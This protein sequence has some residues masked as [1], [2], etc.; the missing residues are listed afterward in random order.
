MSFTRDDPSL[1]RPVG[2]P[3]ELCDYFRAAE[4]A[5]AAFRVGTEHEKIGLVEK[6]LAPVPY[7]G[8]GGIAAL[9][10]ELE[11]RHGFAPLLDGENLIGLEKDGTSI[12]LEPGGQLELSGAPLRTMRE[13]CREF[14]DHVALMKHVSERFG[15]VWLGLGIHPIA[16]VADIPRVPRDRYRIMRDY[17]GERGELA[18]TMMHATGTVQANLDFSSQADVARKLRVALATQPV[19]TALYANSS[20]SEGGPNGFESRRAWIWR[21][22]D[23]DRCGL[24]P[25]V[26]SPEWG[27]ASAYRLYTEWALDVPMLFIQRS[28]VHVEMHGETFRSYLERARGRATLGDWH[29]H[30]TTLFPEVRLKRVI[31]VR[32]ADAVP[33]EGVCAL[34]AF[35][36]GLLYDEASLEAA[37]RRVASWSFESVDR[38]HA[39]VAR[40]GLGAPGPDA[41]VLEVARELLDLA[42][43]GLD[44]LEGGTPSS[45]EPRFL[46]PLYEIVDR[47]KSP[48]R[49]L[50][51]R[52]DGAFQRRMDRT[53]EYARY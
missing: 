11:R 16:K 35:W 15:I 28:A 34:P 51:E 37:H 23:P 33:P 9:L 27:E 22:T 39:E 3:S 24:L 6:T 29:V 19:L 26:F 45:S 41:P 13:T 8:A 25:F 47:G 1:E 49:L 18:L 36:K 40:L 50:L 48:A 14:N 31:E 7:A 30:L 46:D 44:R 17:L 32:G 10:A 5:R 52:W 21:R 38:M 42:S 2:D 43:A 12:T 53:V 20:L 4:K